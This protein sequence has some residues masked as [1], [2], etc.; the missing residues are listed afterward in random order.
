MKVV[1]I[2]ALIVVI[3]FLWPG[4]FVPSIL[5][6]LLLGMDSKSSASVAA[7]S[8]HP[9]EQV[10][11]YNL[12]YA[13]MEA[14]VEDLVSYVKDGKTTETL[15]GIVSRVQD[16]DVLDEEVVR[17]A[18]NEMIGE[19]VDE[20]MERVLIEDEK[21]YE[22]VK[23]VGGFDVDA[24]VDVII[25][26]MDTRLT[27]LLSFDIREIVINSYLLQGK[28]K[29]TP[30]FNYS[31]K[32]EAF[33]MRI[34]DSWPLVKQFMDTVAFHGL[35]Q[36]QY[37]EN[38]LF[39]RI[40]P[41]LIRKRLDF[42]YKFFWAPFTGTFNS[43]IASVLRE[44]FVSLAIAER[45]KAT[46]NGVSEDTAA[47]LFMTWRLITKE[48][49]G[50]DENEIDS[51]IFDDNTRE[52]QEAQGVLLNVILKKLRSMPIEELPK[53]YSFVT[54][55]GREPF[56]FAPDVVAIEK[57]KAI[58]VFVDMMTNK[59]FAATSVLNALN[60]L[61]QEPIRGVSDMKSRIL[62]ARYHSSDDALPVNASIVTFLTFFPDEKR[63]LISAVKSV[64]LLS[65]DQSCSVIPHQQYNF[66]LCWM[67]ASINLVDAF[68]RV[69]GV[70]VDSDVSELIKSFTNEISTLSLHDDACPMIK[71]ERLRKFVQSE[72]QALSSG[73]AT[74]FKTMK[75]YQDYAGKNRCINRIT[76]VYSPL[77][78]MN[79]QLAPNFLNKL[80]NE[81]GAQLLHDWPKHTK[82]ESYRGTMPE[83]FANQNSMSFDVS[84]ND[85]FFKKYV[86]GNIF[87]LGHP[88]CITKFAGANTSRQLV[89]NLLQYKNND[90]ILESVH[91]RSVPSFRYMFEQEFKDK[92]LKSDIDDEDILVG[93]HDGN[94]DIQVMY[95]ILDE[96]NLQEHF[97]DTDFEV[98]G[99]L[100]SFDTQRGTGHIISF[101]VCPSGVHFLDSNEFDVQTDLRKLLSGY[102]TRNLRRLTLFFGYR[103]KLIE[104][105]AANFDSEASKLFIYKHHKEALNHI[106]YIHKFTVYN[107]SPILGE[108]PVTTLV[109]GLLLSHTNIYADRDTYPEDVARLKEHF[110]PLLH[111]R[112]HEDVFDERE[113]PEELK[114]LLKSTFSTALEK[115][116]NKSLKIMNEHYLFE[117]S[118][119][120]NKILEYDLSR[121]Q[122][123]DDTSRKRK[124]EIADITNSGKSFDFFSD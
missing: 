117:R 2:I 76:G 55:Y 72:T 79:Y 31:A 46:G 15:F 74:I 13:L 115:F 23:T 89:V 73:E 120:F 105:H 3:L 66:P 11:K 103:H 53:V 10:I 111:Q 109:V 108:D 49:L 59:D 82:V 38:G 75:D 36:T 48:L 43:K 121:V 67:L 71:P 122:M 57:H 58:R 84:I 99:G 60:R 51:F 123:M 24:L 78:Q 62:S 56:N 9:R 19:K 18:M 68:I 41:P 12:M 25:Q 107:N 69:H 77:N 39:K 50:L 35:D 21:L 20:E 7:R 29:L 65:S 81:W 64:E 4:M 110:R 80:R 27:R 40:F 114:H 100:L 112:R 86:E 14:S 118:R 70:K 16:M 95:T 42:A 22:T 102:T 88:V 6:L 47:G 5:L 97:S 17:E 26:R 91:V 93:F 32:K 33:E 90:V 63:K 116:K 119:L 85:P 124:R 44:D 8:S 92:F 30:L 54:T 45:I 104:H 98:L 37:G 87:F 61:M 101:V 28:K 94:Q 113:I 34:E 106:Q 1:I 52:R 83:M 96:I